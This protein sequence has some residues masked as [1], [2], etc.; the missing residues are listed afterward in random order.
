MRKIIYNKSMSNMGREDSEVNSPNADNKSD[1]IFESSQ[2]KESDYS[3]L[4]VNVQGEEAR[5]RAEKRQQAAHDKNL[6]KSRKMFKANL[7]KQEHISIRKAKQ[8][9]RREWIKRNKKKLIIGASAIAVILLS[10]VVGFAINQIKNP[11]LTERERELVEYGKKN[12]QI[13]ENIYNDVFLKF[14]PENEDPKH[15]ASIYEMAD[16][17][18]ENLDEAERYNAYSKY[19]VFA[20][21]RGDTSKMKE[22]LDIMGGLERSDLDNYDYYSLL[23][24][25]A[26]ETGDEE[27]RQEYYNKAQEYKPTEDLQW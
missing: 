21:G 13:A 25:Y 20:K 10:I 3:D 4:F 11:P 9:A 17:F 24:L 18:I 27:K 1:V 19:V 2:I 23:A 16:E 7:K 26:S 15:L 6:E 22:I 12:Q 14:D 5:K 8:N